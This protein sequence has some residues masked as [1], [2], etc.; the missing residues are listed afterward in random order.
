MATIKLS[1]LKSKPLI[2]GRYKIQIYLCHKRKV[3]YI[4]TNIIVAY[5]Q[6]K[7]GQIY[8]HTESNILNAKLRNIINEYQEKLEEI[9]HINMYDC[10][11]LKDILI[12]EKPK[13]G[14]HT[15]QSYCTKFITQLEDENRNSYADLHKANL[16]FFTEFTRGEMAL[17]DITPS[18]IANYD[19]YLR[20]HTKMNDTTIDMMLGRTRTVINFAKKEQLVKYD[21]DPFAFRKISSSPVRDA[22]ISLT[23]IK[24]IIDYKPKYKKH[25]VARD[26]F[27]LSFYLGGMNLIDMLS[28]D[29]KGKESIT[30]IRT[31]S[32]RLSRGENKIC[33]PVHDKAKEIINKWMGKNGKLDFGYKFEYKNFNCFIGRG[34][35]EMAD[36]LEINDRVIMYSARK[37]FA[38]F[39]S[40]LGIPD[41]VIDHCLGHSDRSRGVIRYYTK[42]KQKQAEI[43]VNRVIDYVFNPD[44]YSDYIK[45]NSDI[46]LMKA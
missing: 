26:V 45:F 28:V 39:A 5:N 14:V 30:Y 4:P 1:V 42:V 21:I 20:K 29:F 25:I 22:A 19:K 13:D 11:Q 3:C 16:K 34:I 7:N 12:A 40:D 2:D 31:K 18:I 23:D 36:E 41:A 8:R 9:K 27:L 17:S 43:A 37:T 32:K 6:F 10:K 46:M 44:K 15:F 38:Q 24:K 33:I 35:R